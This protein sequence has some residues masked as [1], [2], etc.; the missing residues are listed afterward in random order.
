[1][2]SLLDGVDLKDGYLR[3]TLQGSRIN[4]TDIYLQGGEGSSTRITGQ[5][6]NLTE[7]PKSGGTLKGS[8]VIEYDPLAPEGSSGLRMDLRAVADHLQVLVRADR[9]LSVSG[10]LK[11]LLE[12]GQFTLDGKL[13]IDR[14]AI[15]LASD[16]APSLGMT[17]TSPR[18]LPARPQQK[19][20][21][22]KPPRPEAPC[23]SASHRSCMCS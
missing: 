7:A 11:A 19:K 15:I 23:K 3:A 18:P 2:Q 14:A 1:M 10:D 16:S 6:G 12:Q 20:P 4:I 9:Q 17:C 22:A 21:P 8:G 13:T 5:S